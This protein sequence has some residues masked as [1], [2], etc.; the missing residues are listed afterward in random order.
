MRP[1]AIPE[2]AV[3][4]WTPLIFAFVLLP[5]F[6]QVRLPDVPSTALPPALPG[7][8]IDDTVR[9]AADTAFGALDDYTRRIDA[10]VR[11]DRRR[12][13]VTPAGD[14]MR[15]GEYLALDVDADTLARA[16]AA[17]FTVLRHDADD[18]APS[19]AQLRDMRDRSPS[20]GLRALR[21]AMPG[22]T[23]EFHHLYLPAAAA[24]ASPKTSGAAASA[25]GGSRPLRVGLIDGGVDPKEPA[26]SRIA[27][28]RHG[29]DGRVV[30]QRHGT[31]VATR[32]AAGAAGDLFVADLWCG[33]RAGGDTL[34]VIDALRWMA[35][36]RVSVINLSLVGPDNAALKRTVEA[37]ASRGFLLVA[38]AGNDG[39]ASPPRYPAA[40]PAVIAVGAVDARRRP[41]PESAVGAHL[42]FC[43]DGVAAR[44]ARGT[45]FAAPVV[46]HAL[47][48]LVAES[49][50]A[51]P[52]SI[53]A[54][55]ALRTL[56]RLAVDVAS[57][58]RDPHCGA[59]AVS[60]GA[61][62]PG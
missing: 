54:S 60:P 23:V 31:R 36:E 1:V 56:E 58:G 14:V 17:G 43:A 6:A 27:V 16:R 62:S 40:Y 42:D 29:C 5:A 61:S 10:L 47:A 13:D 39:P 34:G 55:Q 21:E 15:R 18:I 7:T 28:H 44:D 19:I 12:V 49:R 11:S 45:S 37:L 41:L 2:L 57:P 50:A 35:R 24:A 9:G 3:P 22:A 51:M 25:P 38:A 8:P 59:G 48:R 30:P 33:A 53:G 4:R 52:T 26:I 32:L 46:A 20:R